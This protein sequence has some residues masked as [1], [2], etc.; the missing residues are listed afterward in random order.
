MA[1]QPRKLQKTS[2]FSIKQKTEVP[3]FRNQADRKFFME[4]LEK[5][6]DKFGYDIYGYCLLDPD[7]FW[8]VL[9]CNN[10]SIAS[11]MQA[12]SISYAL[13]RDDVDN[14]F[15]RRYIS[16]PIYD[17]KTLEKTMEAMISDPRYETCH[18]CFYD[19]TMNLPLPFI[20][21]V[22]EGIDIQ[23]KYLKK[24]TTSEMEAYIKD[25]VL[26]TY[27]TLH[28]LEDLNVRNAVIRHVYANLNVTQ[29]Q[30]SQYFEIGN[31]AI[32]KIVSN[33]I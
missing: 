21:K 17:L 13:Y 12:I 33:L 11:I 10:R 16:E 32:S 6:K 26:E 9:N 31:S 23:T 5:N 15:S 7:A 8:I 29:K 27:E 19:P 18:Y 3:I 24:T 4:L 22:N 1:R 20:S 14:L 25:Y 28:M 2:V 30:L